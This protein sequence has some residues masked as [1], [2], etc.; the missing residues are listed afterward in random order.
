MA[1]TPPRRSIRERQSEELLEDLCIELRQVAVLGNGLPANERVVGHVRQVVA[2]HAE[3]VNR[4][5]DVRPRLE[6]LSEETKWQMLSLLDDCRAYPDQLPLV[7]DL[8]GIRHLLRC[9]LCGQAERA[10]DSTVFWFCNGCMQ[11]VVEAL[12]RRTPLQGIVLF[13]TYNPECRCSH[14]GD[15]SVLAAEAYVEELH[16]A[17]ERCIQDELHRRGVAE[18]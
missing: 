6:H 15:D 5:V 13:R 1:N 10:F 8:D 14:A 2:V 9:R 3:L 18:A 11:R 16:G 7:K 4:G 17:C 12:Q